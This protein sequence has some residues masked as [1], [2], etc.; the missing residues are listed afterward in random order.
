MRS[1]IALVLF[2]LATLIAGVVGTETRL[3]F[4]WPACLLLGVAGLAMVLGPRVRVPYPP[5][6]VCLA[7]ALLAA[8]YFG[9][10]AVASPVVEHAREDFFVIGAGLGA[11]VIMATVAAR[12]VGRNAFLAVMLLLAAGNLAVGVIHFGG[13]WSF[14]VVPAFVR[15]FEEGRIGGFYNNPNHLAA[16]FSMV[17]FMGLGQMCFGRGP[18]TWR[19]VL[20]FV[21]VSAMLGMALT[22]SR[23]ALLALG[24]GGLAFA[25]M[26]TWLVWKCHRHLAGKLAFACV[27]LGVVT[28]AVLWKVN[29]DYLRRRLVEQGASSDVRLDIWQAAL[30]Q[31]AE[32][33]WIGAGARRF[34]EG[35]VRYRQPDVAAW[36]GEPE[37]AHNEY[38]QALADYGWV[39]L[40]LLLA[41]LLAHL[42]N[43]W[44]YVWRYASDCFPRSGSLLSARLALTTGAVAAVFASAVHA[45]VEFHWHVGGLVILTAALAGILASPGFEGGE[46]Q[47]RRL[48]GVRPLLKFTWF[49]YSSCLVAGSF[50]WGRADWIHAGAAIRLER[51]EAEAA[52]AAMEKAGVLDP[53]SARKATDRAQARLEIQARTDSGAE[54]KRLLDGA[55]TD[56]EQAAASNPF[57]FITATSLS[58]VYTA[59]GRSEQ[60][61]SEIRRA[62]SLAPLYE[63]PRLA[64]A[65]F[66]H[67]RQEFQQAEEAYL[68]ASQ[69]G[70]ANAAGT[71]TWLAAYRQLL[72]DA[73]SLPASA[74]ANP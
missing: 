2:V 54:R 39:G 60:A 55:R 42:M 3:L 26:G 5:N 52:L 53:Q 29:E 44:R 67:R 31:H 17:V 70:A 15:S 72:M 56:L 63:E 22:I 21:I 8:L 30:D 34:Y 20:G 47:T 62:L 38:L 11:Y 49:A 33:P 40:I 28:G 50:V 51:G 74:A 19:L 59:L 10:R 68:W 25:G 65:L 37:F 61:L 46:R 66:H 6:E 57:D 43:G 27:V 73:G 41:V 7:T 4:L 48:P 32:Q 69:A 16:F 71:V 64:L 12:P 58:D 45:L 1:R 35:G 14:H 13:D 24:A 9:I 23:G 18:A 36:I